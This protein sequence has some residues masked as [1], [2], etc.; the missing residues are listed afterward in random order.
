MEPTRDELEYLF[1]GTVRDVGRKTNQSLRENQSDM[2]ALKEV[3]DTDKERIDL[4]DST[5]QQTGDNTKTTVPVSDVQ[6][7]LEVQ[8]YNSV[9]R[10]LSVLILF[11][12]HLE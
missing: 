12:Y 10:A 2:M 9:S 4:E 11:T 3:N 7:P 6:K 1:K 5:R 8:R